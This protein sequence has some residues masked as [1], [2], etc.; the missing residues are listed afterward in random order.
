LGVKV[1]IEDWVKL[2]NESL[3]TYSKK[4]YLESI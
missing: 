1:N 3:H 4:L 2:Q